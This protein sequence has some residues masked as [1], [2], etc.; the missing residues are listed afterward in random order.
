[1][2]GSVEFDMYHT[3]ALRKWSTW[4]F[5]PFLQSTAT[6]PCHSCIAMRV[7]NDPIGSRPPLGQFKWW[8]NF[9]H[10]AAIPNT[11]KF[12]TTVWLCPAPRPSR[13]PT[14]SLLLVERAR[15]RA[16]GAVWWIAASDHS[17]TP[18]Q[19]LQFLPSWTHNTP[20]SSYCLKSYLIIYLF[21]YLIHKITI[22]FLPLATLPAEGIVPG[23][24]LFHK[25]ISGLSA[26]RHVAQ[27]RN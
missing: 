3:T 11:Q 12:P 22:F 21:Q 13:S 8:E 6:Q 2:G 4:S 15:S 14:A 19:M 9:A 25:R 27:W 18:P 16:Q 26:T 23:S 7:C 1:M 5:F 24:G 20:Y 17:S 10:Q